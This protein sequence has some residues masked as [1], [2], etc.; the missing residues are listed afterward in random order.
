THLIL[1]HHISPPLPTFYL[2]FLYCSGAHRDL[3]SF[4]T[5][6]SS[7]LISFPAPAS[8]AQRTPFP[9]TFPHCC[10]APGQR[11]NSR[12]P[13]ASGFRFPATFPFLAA[14][15]MPRSSAPRWLRRSQTLQS[16]APE[17]VRSMLL[18]RPSV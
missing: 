9:T 16:Q 11:A 6:R 17:R 2:F 4:P 13:L 12:S 14:L 8:P 15:P 10:A 5:R 7:D 3:H 18:L 1:T